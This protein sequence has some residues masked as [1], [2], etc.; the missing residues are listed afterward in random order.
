MK[1]MAP[2]RA[3]LH[4]PLASPATTNTTAKARETQAATVVAFRWPSRGARRARKMRPP[5]M[6]RAGTRLNTPM[7]R[8]RAA[9]KARRSTGP[10][11]AKLSSAPARWAATPK[12]PARVKDTAGPAAAIRSSWVGVRGDSTMRAMPPRM[13]RSMLAMRMR[14]RCATTA[15]PSSWRSTEPNRST[16]AGAPIHPSWTNMSATTT[17]R[18][19]WRRTGI[20]LIT[21]I[22]SALN[23]SGPS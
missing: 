14:K 5:S 13:C 20:P 6:G 16:A 3:R 12:A 8:L 18:L 15:C 10:R 1:S 22:W 19:T 11:S 9:P 4:A 2:M 7:P 21:A 17:R 23:I